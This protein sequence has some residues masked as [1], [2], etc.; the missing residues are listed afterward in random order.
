V[1]NR[2]YKISIIG[3]GRIGGTI[4]HLAALKNLGHIVLFD[5]DEGLAQGKALDL[6]HSLAT[7]TIIGTHSYQDI[8]DS[9]VVIVTAGTARTPGVTSRDALCEANVAVM[10]SVAEAIKSYTP[11]AF[12]IVITNPVDVMTYVMHKFAELNRNMVLGMSGILD[13]SRYNYF[14]SQALGVSP[15]AVQGIVLGGH[16]DDMVPLPRLTTVGGVPL[17][18]VLNQKGLDEHALTQVIEKTRYG[19]TTILNLLKTSAFYAPASGAVEMLEAYLHDQKKILPCSVCLNG[20][21]D[22]RDV[23]VGVPVVIGQTGVEGVIELELNEMEQMNF[24]KSAQSVEMMVKSIGW[25]S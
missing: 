22:V 19:G 11:S 13:T 20:E 18:E 9:D 21:Y 6:S 25:T 7:D 17:M 2:V 23:C 16:G 8:T 14:L 24:K 12:V 10:R 1:E 3:A 4:A 5:I 15:K